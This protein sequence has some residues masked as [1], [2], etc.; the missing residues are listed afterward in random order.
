MKLDQ[1]FLDQTD[2]LAY[3]DLK[4]ESSHKLLKQ[5][6]LALY[7]EDMSENIISGDFENKIRLDLILEGLIINLAIDKD[8][9][10]KDQYIKIIEKYLEKPT[11][12]KSQNVFKIVNENPHKA[13]FLLSGG[14]IINSLDKYNA[15][16]YA[17]LLWRKAYED[18]EYKDEFIKEAL[19]IL[20]DIISQD[21][22]IP[23][24]FYELGNI[25]S[26]LGEYI[27]ARDRKSTR[28]NSSH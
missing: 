1:Y 12:Y 19:R 17:R 21:E 13:L 26:N 2:K 25:Y 7:T 20:Q 4:E 18:S 3:I 28:L 6:P 5:V 24:S 23:L 10:Y 9:K 15:Y 11:A 27:K 8:F 22:Y 16:N 14:Y